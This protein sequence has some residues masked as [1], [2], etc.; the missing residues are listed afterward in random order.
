MDNNKLVLNKPQAVWLAIANLS[1]NIMKQTGALIACNECCNIE[2]NEF[3]K[4][5]YDAISRQLLMDIAKFFDRA[6]TCGNE[7]CSIPMLRELC[8]SY[9]DVF[10]GSE[11]DSLIKEIDQLVLKFEDTISKQVRNK[12]L[13]H[14]DLEELF[15]FNDVQISFTSVES[16]VVKLGEVISKI[17]IHLLLI[18]VEFPSIEEY[19]VAYKNEVNKL[20][21]VNCNFER[22]L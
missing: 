4:I 1:T 14:F 19:A 7:N 17:G 21:C 10:T 11:I 6:T 2:E 12:K 9:K 18:K 20:M 13:A 22:K 15:S 16:L 3:I 8:L 5:A